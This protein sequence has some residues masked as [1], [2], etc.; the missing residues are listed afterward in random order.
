MQ[1][2]GSTVALGA[3]IGGGIA[4][5]A[6]LGLDSLVDADLVQKGAE[7]TV[8]QLN[9]ELVNKGVAYYAPPNFLESVTNALGD[10]VKNSGLGS[11]NDIIVNTL[12]GPKSIDAS[13][14]EK[15]IATQNLSESVEEHFVKLLNDHNAAAAGSSAAIAPNAVATELSELLQSQN[16]GIGDGIASMHPTDIKGLVQ[17]PLSDSGDLYVHPEKFVEHFDT[18]A[19]GANPEQLEGLK[20]LKDHLTPALDMETVGI[21]AGVGGLTGAAVSAMKPQTRL[22][23]GAPRGAQPMQMQLSQER[24]V[25]PKEEQPWA[26]RMAQAQPQVDGTQI[27]R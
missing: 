17:I 21:G 25:M 12:S 11:E 15:I 4:A 8:G 20:A 27:L 9:Q 5:A 10:V 16:V 14:L 26:A 3:V 2:N 22:I 18:I 1:I 13:T 23:A 6:A 19:K 7:H 24:P